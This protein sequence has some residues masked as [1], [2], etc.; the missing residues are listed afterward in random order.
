[1]HCSKVMGQIKRMINKS[2]KED[3]FY[4]YVVHTEQL[5]KYNSVFE[6]V[7]KVDLK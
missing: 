1:M 6:N 2:Q 7:Y 5:I 4:M 3:H